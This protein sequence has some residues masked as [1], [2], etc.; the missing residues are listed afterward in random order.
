MRFIRP[1]VI[2]ICIGQAASMAALLL[3]AG[4][5]GKRFALPNSRIMI[6][7]PSMSG[8]S[9]QATDI[10]I[11]AKEILRMREITTQILAESTKQP[12]ERVLRDVERDFIMGPGEAK[13]YGLID[14]V[15]TKR[16][17]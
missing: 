15:I 14:K 17:M 5:P 2:T 4:A 11:H 13:D 10:D 8:L 16:G 1:E 7:Q 9:G 6:H 3:A 12:Y